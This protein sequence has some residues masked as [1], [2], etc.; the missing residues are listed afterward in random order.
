MLNAAKQRS[1]IL[2]KRMQE[3]GISHAVFTSES[4]IAYLAGFWGYLKR[5]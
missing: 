2:Q 3:L 1:E 5:F 4:S